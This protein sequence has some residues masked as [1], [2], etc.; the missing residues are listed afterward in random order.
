[1]RS[2]LIDRT[3]SVIAAQGLDKTTTKAIVAGTGINE[4]YIYRI[5]TDKEDLLAKT[6]EALDEELV[7]KTLQHIPIMY[8]TELE[9]ETR[10]RLFFYAIWQFLVGNSKKCRAYMQYYY[11]P[12]FQ[13]N[14]AAEHKK[15]FT[16]LEEK[17]KPAFRA[18]AATWLILNH[19]LN[20]VLDFAL[21]V[22][23]GEMP[24]TDN[25]A[26]HMFRVIYAS[27]KQYF[28]NN[29]ESDS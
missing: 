16:P 27:V 12:Y 3:I 8:M 17:F 7:A 14:S 20:V 1:M 19:M 4:A 13:K 25:Y 15:R 5:F 28:K 11:S 9:F 21:R 26:E 29:E 18:K 24:E 2:V 10:C 6:F 23:N 22:F